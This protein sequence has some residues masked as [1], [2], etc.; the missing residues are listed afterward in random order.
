MK[1]MKASKEE[2]IQP[3]PK[4]SVKRQTKITEFTIKKVV[5]A[6]TPSRTQNV[7]KMSRMSARKR[8]SLPLKKQSVTKSPRPVRTSVLVLPKVTPLAISPP[9]RTLPSNIP[10]E[11][12]K[13]M[14]K[15][16]QEEAEQ[17]FVTTILTPLKRQPNILCETKV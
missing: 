1:P 17:Q 6:T 13:E 12:D 3:T 16:A 9:M 14:F 10:T 5:P 7:S 2:P 15:K 8:Q 11:A 4:R